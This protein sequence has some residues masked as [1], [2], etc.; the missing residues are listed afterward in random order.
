M[1]KISV[2]KDGDILAVGGETLNQ[3]QLQALSSISVSPDDILDNLDSLNEELADSFET[4]PEEVSQKKLPEAKVPKTKKRQRAK[5]MKKSKSAVAR[6]PSMEQVN[7]PGRM[8]LDEELAA[9]SNNLDEREVEAPEEE[10]VETDDGMRSQIMELLQNTPG[11]PNAA[12]IESWKAKLGKN[13]VHVMALGEGDVYIY[14]HLKRGQWK[15]IQELMTKAQQTQATDV[16]EMLKEKVVTY[17][18][19]WPKPLPVEFFYNSR[20]GVV[21]SLYQVILLNSY[22]LS[23]QQAMILTT[24]LQNFKMDIDAIINAGGNVFSTQYPDIGLTLTYRLLSLKEYKAFKGLRDSGLLDSYQVGDAVF[25]R[26]FLGDM[27][28]LSEDL[29][30]G[31][32]ISVGSL[33]LYLS[34]DCDGETLQEDIALSRMLHP[35]DTVF[36]YMRS[37]IVTAFPAYTI[38]FLESLARPQFI[39]YFTIAENVLQ[40]QNPEYERLN[41]KGIKTA[42]EM[43]QEKAAKESAPA[44]DFKAENRSIRK[45]VG[46]FDIEEAEQGKLSRGQLKKLQSVSRG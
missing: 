17:C 6:G 33:I 41:L 20:A 3:E 5:Q 39:R 9:L 46:H 12:T 21:D 45:A 15:K 37:V 25:A 11:A 43:A 7:K 44:I 16:E 36:E 8:S 4:E 13:A 40:K 10:A 2:R 22:F 24:Q 18:T 27:G 42:E 34:G 14:T 1:S 29:P 38:D 30:A 19:L 35:A 31:I 23:P 26:C 28:F 32:T